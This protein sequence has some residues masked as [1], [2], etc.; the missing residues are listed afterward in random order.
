[1]KRLFIICCFFL[2]IIYQPIS[3]QPVSFSHLNTSNGL[4]E[5]NAQCLAID[6]NGFLWIGTTN[7]LNCY[8]G[9]GVTA[10]HKTQ[11]PA[12]S[13]DTIR[14]LLCD[15]RNRIWALSPHGAAWADQEKKFTS[16]ALPT[17]GIYFT[18]Y[19]ILES[20]SYGIIL[21]TRA[22]H[23]YFNDKKSE[24][25]K[26]DWLSQLIPAKEFN[27]ARALNRDTAIYV[28]EQKVVVIDYRQ[29]KIFFEKAIPKAVTACDFGKE[30]MA[31]ATRH[32][33]IGIFDIRR[34]LELR[35]YQLDDH[36]EGQK[37]G[38]AVSEMYKASNGSL[39][40]ATG[41]AG[42]IMIDSV[43][44]A[45]S[46]YLHDPI[47]PGSVCNNQLYRVLAG[48]S[49]EIITGSISSGVSICNINNKQ[50][51]Y[52]RIF[53]DEKGNVFDGHLSGVEEDKEK[54]LWLAGVDRLVRWDPATNKSSFF[55][56]YINTERGF[57][58]LEI[59]TLCI[60]KKDRVW[61]G[62]IGAG[63]MLFNKQ[64]EKFQVIVKDTSLGKAV[65]NTYTN[66]LMEDSDG[67]IWAGTYGGLYTIDPNSHRITVY[68]DHPL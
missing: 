50:A 31:V 15:S 33:W 55:Q 42:L 51:S 65:H 43:T 41:Q 14:H 44:G 21:F 36:L 4:T 49:G 59:R 54:I 30:S 66:D 47:N 62:T 11:H 45:I 56:Y 23:F 64:I 12:L 38:I 32:G 13:S 6:K 34:K 39:V 35:K 16:V 26:I 9:Y 29:K 17:D 7:G 5:N 1:M 10:Y 40:M 53:K 27:T 52:K 28:F 3:G 25:Q 46:Q 24:W 20:A 61:V 2:L 8:D 68:D 67:T 22:G 60:D 58:N 48:K 19:N 57:R 63:V 37:T 18:P